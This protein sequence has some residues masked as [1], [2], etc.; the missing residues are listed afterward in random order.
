MISP[1]QSDDRVF[2]GCLRLQNLMDRRGIPEVDAEGLEMLFAAID[3]FAAIV[4]TLQALFQMEMKQKKEAGAR[5]VPTVSP[6]SADR[7]GRIE[8]SHRAD[9]DCSC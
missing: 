6:Q 2:S 7:F 3:F 1:F 4:P 8:D 5:I 9:G